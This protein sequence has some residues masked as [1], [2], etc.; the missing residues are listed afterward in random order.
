M[1]HSP[2]GSSVQ[3]ILQAR[4]L[5]WVAMRSSRL[6]SYSGLKYD[7][8]CQGLEGKGNGKLLFNG[9]KFSV[10]DDK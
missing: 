1:D 3:E 9:Y 8:G 7:D 5:E 6:E 2:P 4:I 10:T